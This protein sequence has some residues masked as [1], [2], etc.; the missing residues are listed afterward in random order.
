MNSNE[1]KRLLSCGGLEKYSSLY[2]DTSAEAQRMI[3]AVERFEEL[4]G[5][6]REVMLLSV[7]FR[8][9]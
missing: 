6:G 2:S 8:V 1:L 9:R 4:Y 3:A 7:V 5:E